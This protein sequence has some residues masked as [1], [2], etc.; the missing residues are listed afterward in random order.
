MDKDW[1]EKE[2]ERIYAECYWNGELKKGFADSLRKVRREAIESCAVIAE[3]WKTSLISPTNS[4]SD[5]FVEEVCNSVSVNIA[6]AIRE[7]EG[8]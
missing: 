2:V 5:D 3:E 1:A 6:Q 8:L 7:S 4:N